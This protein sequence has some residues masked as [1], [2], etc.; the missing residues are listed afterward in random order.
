MTILIAEISNMH[1]GS[2]VKAKQLIRT[3]AQ[4]GADMVKGQAFVAK[5]ML[6]NGV[7]TLEFYQKCALSFYDYIELLEYAD[8]IG[9]IFFYSVLSVKMNMITARQTYRKVTAKQFAN[10]S[11]RDIRAVDTETTFISMGQLREIELSNAHLMYA[12]QYNQPI[13]LATY[14]DM[15]HYYKRPIGISHHE[16]VIKPLMELS[17]EYDLPVIEKHFYLGDDIV[18]DGRRYRDCDHA[19]NPTNFEILA[20][21]V[22]GI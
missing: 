19:A 13:C 3:A 18:F 17:K 2:M 15:L 6:A 7:M 10:R 20:K 9:T 8:S 22:K 12:Y 16:K 11:P 4:C 1:L 14:Q 5:D 21:A